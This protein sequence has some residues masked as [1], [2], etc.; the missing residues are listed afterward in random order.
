MNT[1]LVSYTNPPSMS[2]ATL[3]SKL[4]PLFVTSDKGVSTL[5]RHLIITRRA[6]IIILI[7][8]FTTGA[9]FTLILRCLGRRR[10]S[11]SETTHDSLSL[12]DMTNT[13]FTW[14]NSSLRVS[15]RASMRTCYAMMVSMVIPLVEDERTEVDIVV[16]ARGATAFVRGYLGR[17][18]AALRRTVAS[19][20]HMKVKWGDSG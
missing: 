12:C 6:N 14:H 2:M 15:K 8:V 3:I 5:S 17:S 1:S 13:V 4:F 20:A 11:H 16:E 18:C 19:M 9:I 10:R 7:S